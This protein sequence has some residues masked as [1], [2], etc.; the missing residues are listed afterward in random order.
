MSPQGGDALSVGG[1]K[2]LF[3]QKRGPLP[4]LGYCFLGGEKRREGGGLDLSENSSLGGGRGE[5]EFSVPR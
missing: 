1:K 2:G 4:P 3:L 5:G